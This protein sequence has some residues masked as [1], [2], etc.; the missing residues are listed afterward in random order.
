MSEL[1]ID[2]AIR[3][4]LA[5][6]IIVLLS[7]PDP[8][9]LEGEIVQLAAINIIAAATQV[10]Q[11]EGVRE[12]IQKSL[13]PLAEKTIAQVD[14]RIQAAG[15]HVEELAVPQG[16]VGGISE[17]DAMAIVRAM[18]RHGFLYTVKAE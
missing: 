11:N 13:A 2:E 7:L 16:G 1:T 17:W 8:P 4:R 9:P 6:W 10:L 14:R 15:M 12:S 3:L 18:Q 5:D